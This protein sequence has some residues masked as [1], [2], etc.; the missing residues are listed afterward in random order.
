MDACNGRTTIC[1]SCR[2]L[3]LVGG[4]CL[5]PC[6]VTCLSWTR[7]TMCVARLAKCPC[8]S[9]TRVATISCHAQ[10]HPPLPCLR[11]TCLT[12]QSFSV[13]LHGSRGFAHLCL[14]FR[15]PVARVPLTHR[16]SHDYCS[17]F[18]AGAW[19]FWVLHPVRHEY[20]SVGVQRQVA[21]RCF[22]P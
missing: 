11:H 18:V 6:L 19:T 16:I 17:S 13:H 12:Q 20:G 10:S 7:F 9:T 4:V 14:T 5:A 15:R 3:L 22:K 21:I 8:W 2:L 1:D